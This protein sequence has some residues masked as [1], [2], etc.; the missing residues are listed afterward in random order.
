M[1]FSQHKYKL[2]KYNVFYQDGDVQYMWNTY[3]NALIK[4][5]RDGQ[6]YIR[7]FSGIEDKSNEF[8]MLKDNGFIVYEKLDEYGRICLEEKQ[9]I[10]ST[11][12]SD[13]LSFVIAPGTGCNYKCSYCFEANSDLT[14]VMTSETAIEVA[15]Y[16]CRLAQCNP[17]TKEISILWFGGEPLIYMDSIEIIS[18]KVMDFANKNNIIYATRMATNGRYLNE[19]NLELIQELGIQSIQITVD[20]MRE[21]YCKSKVASS[22]DFDTVIDNIIRAVEKIKVKVRVNIPDNDANEAIAITEYLL[23]K[24]NLVNKTDINFAYV[25]DYTLPPEDARQRFINYVNNYLKWIEYILE[26][27]GK[28]EVDKVFKSDERRPLSCGLINATYNSCIG[29]HGELYKCEHS[30]GVDAMI[31]GDIWH[32]RFYNKAELAYYI[33]IDTPTRYM[34]SQCN[35]LPVCMGGCK[36]DYVNGFIA[37]DCDE[38]KKFQFILKLWEGGIYIHA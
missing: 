19:R 17:N 28:T 15:E 38:V 24:C 3:S 34:C 30:F 8:K 5:D 37:F 1:N 7:T 2:S 36:N 10:F 23:S 14:R 6:K 16:I 18:R 13:Y 29:P 12:N 21:V 22:N 27:Y 31:T 11:A 33:T 25:C 35:H 20:G 26:H 4:L 9:A 32:G